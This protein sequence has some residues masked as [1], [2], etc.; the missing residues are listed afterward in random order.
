[1]INRWPSVWSGSNQFVT[2]AALFRYLHNLTTWGQS[3]CPCT[4]SIWTPTDVRKFLPRMTLTFVEYC[5]MSCP[6]RWS[7]IRNLPP[8]PS[9]KRKPFFY[10]LAIISFWTIPFISISFLT[11]LYYFDIYSCMVISIFIGVTNKKAEIKIDTQILCELTQD[12]WSKNN[13]CL[14]ESLFKIEIFSFLC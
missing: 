11:V 7:F 13:C 5:L 8:P 4:F 1:M 14:F 10:A 6:L 9:Q 2:S 12:I 3:I